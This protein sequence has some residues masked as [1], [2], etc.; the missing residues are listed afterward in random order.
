[1]HIAEIKY[2][3]NSGQ[4]FDHQLNVSYVLLYVMGRLCWVN[5][6]VSVYVYVRIFSKTTVHTSPNTEWD[7]Q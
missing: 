4:Y 6:F 1:M 3:N 7:S 2:P 5:S